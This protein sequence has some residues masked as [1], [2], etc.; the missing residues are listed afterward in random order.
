[1]I[2][3]LR[4]KNSLEVRM[5]T[6]SP[7]RRLPA[8]TAGQRIGDA[9]RDR[10]AAALSDHFAEGRL[11]RDEFD[12]R[13]TA[14]YAARTAGDLE[15]LFLDLPAPAPERTSPGRSGARVPRAR[16]AFAVPVLPLLLLVAVV[17]AVGTEPRFPFFVFPLLWFAGGFRRRRG[18]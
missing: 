16:R 6:G 11:D 10:A 9:E 17:T 13:L 1:M 5:E 18:W 4:R 12:V 14:A 15:P 2:T 7:E 3:E 8:L